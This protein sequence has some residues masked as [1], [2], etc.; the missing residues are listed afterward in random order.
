MVP[1]EGISPDSIFFKDTA[2]QP[3]EVLIEAETAQEVEA[4]RSAVREA[5]NQLPEKQKNAVTAVWLNGMRPGEY[6]TQSG[7]SKSS[8]SNHLNRG[9]DNLRKKLE[10]V[11]KNP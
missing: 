8:V 9:F 11:F 5:V 1:L 3:D 4:L 10:K 2:P 6:A 7:M